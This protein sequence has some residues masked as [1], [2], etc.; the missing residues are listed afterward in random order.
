MPELGA[1]A[2]DGVGTTR[3][4]AARTGHPQFRVAAGQIRPGGAKN[5]VITLKNLQ[6]SRIC[7]ARM[8]WLLGPPVCYVAT[9][10]SSQADASGTVS[11]AGNLG[12]GEGVEA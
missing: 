3:R 2:V 10:F 4:L 9:G 7:Y 1:P 11:A 8:C 6:N 12:N 5:G